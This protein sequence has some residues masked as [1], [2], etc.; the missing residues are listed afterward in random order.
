VVVV[1]EGNNV[2]TMKCGKGKRVVGKW[3]NVFRGRKG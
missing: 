3:K 2:K 1:V